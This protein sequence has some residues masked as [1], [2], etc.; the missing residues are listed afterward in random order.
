MSGLIF[1]AGFLMNRFISFTNSTPLMVAI[2]KLSR[3]RPKISRDFT[4]MNLS[5]WVEAPT[6]RPMRVVTTSMRGPR[7]VSARRRV[8]PLSFRRLPKKSMPS[9]GRPEGTMKAV[10]RKPAMG[11]MIFSFCDTV[12]GAGIRMRR[13][14]LL[15]SRSMMGFWI[16]GT[17]AMYE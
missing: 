6:V 16:T 4:E 8:T 14:F 3:P 1:F 5:A 15:V 11:K 7:A 2:T 13:S 17:R 12:R 9:S 10:M